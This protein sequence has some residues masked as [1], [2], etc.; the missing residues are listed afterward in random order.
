MFEREFSLEERNNLLKDSIII[1]VMFAFAFVVNTGIR[2]SGLY[3]DDLY[4]WSCYGEQSFVEYVFPVG[5]TRFRPVYWFIA[6]LELGIIGN[7]ITWIVPFNIIFA[8]IISAFLYL[9]AKQLSASRTVGLIA[10]IMFL[11]SRFSYYNISQLLG[12]MEAVCL[13]FLLIIVYNLYSCLT[14][15][16]HSVRFVI[17][18]IFYFLICFTHER[19]M[20]ILPMFFYVLFIKKEKSIRL[21]TAPFAAFVLVQIVRLMSTG[22]VMPAGTGS[23]F[24]KDTFNLKDFI[25]NLL[26]EILYI[27]GINAGPEHLNGITW[28]DT[29]M[30]IKLF[31]GGAALALLI[32]IIIYIRNQITLFMH[33]K[34]LS[35]AAHISLLLLG[36]MAGCIVASAVTIRVE[37]RWVYAPYMLALLW[38]AHIYGTIKKEKDVDFTKKI[39]SM[40]IDIKEYLPFILVLIW[41]VLMLPVE[42]Y[43]HLKYGNIYLFPDQKRYNALADETYGKYGSKVFGKKIYIIGNHYEMSDFT[44]KTFFKVFDPKRKAEGTS[45]EF[46]ESYRDFGQVT[47]NMLVIE[48][49]VASNTFVDVTDMMR[50][51]K[52]EAVRGY[53]DDGWLD[54]EAE[55]NIMAGRTGIIKLEFMYPGELEGYENISMTMDNSVRLDFKLESN[56]SYHEFEVK[57]YEIINLKIKNNF[58]MKAAE[59]KRGET[60]LSLLVNI[61]SN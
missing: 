44:A 11:C 30:I 5:S 36:T 18:V 28:A 39:L 58:Y 6:W 57:P 37:M 29:N 13:L 10:G 51:V 33:Q 3:M 4:M 35:F 55:L 48:E 61:E 54:E 8:G 60:N 12:L 26:A 50:S 40:D 56:I 21:W 43:G 19:Y 45:V 38:L 24:V 41:A 34:I 27:L 7:N 17:A 32:I 53:Y 31:V 22:A 15:K 20:A 59:E 1:L 25:K 23:T 14:E 9:F 47:S 49:D 16:E 46:V 42:I 52:C 2:I